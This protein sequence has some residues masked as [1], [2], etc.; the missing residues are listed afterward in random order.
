M[1][2]YLSQ[3]NPSTVAFGCADTDTDTTHL[4]P[5]AP[6]TRLSSAKKAKARRL[7]RLRLRLPA[8]KRAPAPTRRISEQ[9]VPVPSRGVGPTRRHAE[10]VTLHEPLVLRISLLSPFPG[11]APEPL[12]R[13]GIEVWSYKGRV[14]AEVF[15]LCGAEN[16]AFRLVVMA[17]NEPVTIVLP[18]H[19]RGALAVASH[20]DASRRPR[21]SCAPAVRRALRRGDVHFGAAADTREDEVKVQTRGRITLLMMSDEGLPR[22][23]WFRREAGWFWRRR[24]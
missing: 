8:K 11:D 18:A 19:F 2:R 10:I 1:T 3:P 23:E 20:A 5:E 15:R 22:E 14:R 17:R 24:V 21:V 13:S 7:P 12:A 9:V 4:V 16:H 6:S